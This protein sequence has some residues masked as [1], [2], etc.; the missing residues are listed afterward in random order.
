MLKAENLSK[1]FIVHHNPLVRI[2][3]PD[4]VVRAIDGI[5]LNLNKGEILGLIGESGSGKTTLAKTLMGLYRPAEGSV[6]YRD[7]DIHSLNREEYRRFRREVQIIFQDPDS[8]LDPRLK[9]KS[10]LEEPLL[11]H[12]LGD[13]KERDRR[14]RHAMEQ[15]NLTQSF[16]GRYPSELSGGQRKRVVIARVL[17]LEPQIIIADEPLAGLDNIVGMQILRLLLNLKKEL[18]LSYLLISHDLNLVNFVCDRVSVIYGG[19]IVETIDGESFD[20]EACHP[21]TNF[22]RG[23]SKAGNDE[24]PQNHDLHNLLHHS[25]NI[26]G[27]VDNCPERTSVCSQNKPPIKDLRL[28][29]SVR[30]HM[31]HP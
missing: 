4:H 2:G 16:S 14:I 25:I 15:V 17:L 1:F 6:Y 26:C 5:S 18:N 13:A 11:I 9:V 12:H 20:K 22:L 23:I 21:Y 3:H 24:M 27:Y 8:T 28:G 31:V 29:H 10:L 19:K 7:T 30:C